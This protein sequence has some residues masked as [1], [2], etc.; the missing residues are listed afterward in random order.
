MLVRLADVCYRRRWRVVLAWV[1][2]LFATIGLQGAFGGEFRADFTND[3]SESGTAFELL[4]ERF[5]ARAG[6]TI[7]I[8][9]RADAGASDPA[10]VARITALTD[11]IEA[12]APDLVDGATTRPGSQSPNIGVVELQ[13]AIQADD[14]DVPV[15]DIRTIVGLI[16]EANAPGLQVEAGGDT[17]MWAEEQEFGSEALGLLAAVIILLVAFGSVVSAGLPIFI[18]M[19]GIGIATGVMMLLAVI[20]Q[21]PD[22][23]PQMAN[24]MGIGVGIDYALF[25]LSRYKQGLR[26]GLQPRDAVVLAVDTAGRAVLFAGATVVIAILGL[27]VM[28]LGFLYGLAASVSFAVLIVMA[29]SLTLLPALLGF[30]GHTIDRFHIPFVKRDTERGGD[31]NLAHR[32]ARVVQRY[33]WPAAIVALVILV[34]LALPAL[35]LRFGFP[36]ASNNPET[37]TTRRAFDLQ[38][39]AF[40]A[41]ANGPLMIVADSKSEEGLAA[42]QRAADVARQ[43]PEVT[44]V[45]PVQPSPTGDAAMA[46]V[47]PRSGPQEPETEQLVGRLR[48][49]INADGATN[50]YIGGMTAAFVDQNDYLVQRLPYFIGA[51]VLL[52]FLLLMVVFRSILVPVKA[53]IMNLLSIGAAYGVVS[54]SVNGGWVGDLIGIEEATPVPGFIPM[55]MFAILF[56]LSMDYEVF[57][58]SRI[59]EEYVRTGD[60]AT[61]VAEGLA[62]TARVI[63]AAAAIMVSVF[64]AFLLGDIIFIKMVGLGLATAIFID[65]SV[66]RLVLVPATMEL[67][68]DRNWWYPDWLDRITPHLS[69]E[70]SMKDLDAELAEVLGG[71]PERV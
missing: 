67:L 35:D 60:N 34:V 25:I 19:L 28:G 31:A 61:A 56:G 22:F 54:L 1:V 20:L 71:E 51:V 7:D 43:D 21:V 30:V 26:D 3:E 33:P 65:A 55:M 45:L 48:E 40:G 23:A 13:L 8:V 27:M 5:P 58:L 14:D 17:V 41:G 69:V 37:M 2:L 11:A 4:E 42:L 70:G 47:L 68:G 62:A 59:R 32:W 57:L 64:G 9:Y 44:F 49:Q 66:V 15:E 38:T 12:A 29:A 63:T 53:A 36:D 24:M 46:L 6:S 10:V 16:E 52:S 50:F 39:E 18:A